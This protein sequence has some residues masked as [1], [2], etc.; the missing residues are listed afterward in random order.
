MVSG[1][2]NR[3]GH[4][5]TPVRAQGV[6]ALDPLADDHPG[7]GQGGDHSRSNSSSRIV[8]LNRSTT[9]FCWGDPFSTAADSI[10]SLFSHARGMSAVNSQPLSDRKIAGFAARDRKQSSSRRRTSRAP[11]LRATNA[12]TRLVDDVQQP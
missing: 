12:P 7:F 2:R 1:E 5:Q 8:P 11:M 9:Q 3:G 4:A 10:P 6:G